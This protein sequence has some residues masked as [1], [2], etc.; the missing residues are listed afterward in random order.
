MPH[1]R[2]LTLGHC[3]ALGASRY[4]LPGIIP[5]HNRTIPA[6][7]AKLA[8]PDWQIKVYPF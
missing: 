1:A 7:A 2:A 8:V 6:E 3:Q 4:A 5:S